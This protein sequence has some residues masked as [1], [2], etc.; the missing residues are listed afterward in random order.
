M[1]DAM[2]QIPAPCQR[3]T[4]FYQ[5]GCHLERCT[6]ISTVQ[7]GSIPAKAMKLNTRLL[8]LSAILAH[9]GEKNLFNGKDLTGCN[10]APDRR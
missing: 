6:H 10:L 5:T 9:A 4:I 8:A 7:S 3:K 1:P 2:R